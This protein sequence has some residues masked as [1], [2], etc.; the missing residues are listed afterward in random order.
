MET[1]FIFFHAIFHI[2]CYRSKAKKKKIILYLKLFGPCSGNTS[3]KLILPVLESILLSINNNYKALSNFSGILIYYYF[4]IL[5]RAVLCCAVLCRFNSFGL[6][7]FCSV[8]RSGFCSLFRFY[9]K[10]SL[11][12]SSVQLKWWSTNGFVHRDTESSSHHIVR[13]TTVLF[14][15]NF[16]LR[17]AYVC[18]V[19]AFNS[20]TL[21]SR[22]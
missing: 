12:Q 11:F 20:V 1:H 2:K 15:Y 14:H 7:C 3:V 6:L 19:C 9:S 18:S 13:Q 4:S 8:Y 5:C 21:C 16:T 22:F 10:Y 17:T